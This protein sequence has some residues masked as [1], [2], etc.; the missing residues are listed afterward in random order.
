MWA[1]RISLVMYPRAVSSPIAVVPC[2][3]GA[4]APVLQATARSLWGCHCLYD[5]WKIASAPRLMPEL[6]SQKTQNLCLLPPELSCFITQLFNRHFGP[7][8]TSTSGF[9]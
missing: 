4:S 3:S 8:V 5:C 9:W 7:T 2:S 1:L 6:E